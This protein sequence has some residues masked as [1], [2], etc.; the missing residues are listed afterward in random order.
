[1][2]KIIRTIL[3]T[4]LLVTLSLFA[5]SCKE[6]GNVPEDENS[7][8]LIGDRFDLTNQVLEF[9]KSTYYADVDYDLADVYAAYGLVSSLGQYN[10]MNSV[11]DLLASSSDGK[12]FG[13]IIRNTRYNE[14]L[15]D[16]ILEG[17]PFLVES[18]GFTP[19][20]GDEIVAINGSR[21]SGL[22]TSSYSAFLS[23]LPSDSAVLFTLKRGEET[24]DVSY[25][26]VDFDFPYCVYI[27]DLSG[28]PT[29][30]GYIWLRSFANT[31][32]HKTESEFREAVKAFNRDGNRAL[33]LDLRGNGG[34]SSQ[35]FA[36]VASAL[37]GDDVP[38]GTGLL[39]VKYEKQDRSAIVRSVAAE[40][41]VDTPIYVLCDGQT[42]SASEALIGTMK[43]H[44]TLTALVG[45][46]TVGKGVAQNGTEDSLEN[47]VGYFVDRGLNADGEETDIGAYI[48]QVIVGRYYIYDPAAEGGKYCMHE[49]PFVPDIPVTGDNVIEPDYGKDIYI[50]AVVEHYNAQKNS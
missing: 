20:R 26:K 41:R 2:K 47:S 37:I 32:D 31:K 21:V 38:V 6:K 45:Q 11:A 30:F 22:D 40:Y 48:I 33:I 9:I 14:H 3:I 44:G 49:K 13:L 19:T 24:H 34:G 43:A 4:I 28:V 50:H 35:V 42:A 10:Y 39:E 36:T 46:K 7:T 5:F 25:Q 29:D 15:I 1:M 23:T 17:S 8:A 18:N 12:G 27:D 16:F